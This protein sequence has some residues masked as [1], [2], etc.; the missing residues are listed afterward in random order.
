MNEHR[1]VSRFLIYISLLF[2]FDSIL[3]L[4]GFWNYGFPMASPINLL[5]NA[6]LATGI[7]L[8]DVHRGNLEE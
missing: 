8:W 5:V 1:A 7:V 3:V 4:S 2:G 6:A